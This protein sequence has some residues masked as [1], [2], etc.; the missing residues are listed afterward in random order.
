MEN[1]NNN[2]L[3]GISKLDYQREFTNIKNDLISVKRRLKAKKKVLSA[4]KE[5]IE[6]VKYLELLNNPKVIKYLDINEEISKLEY[7]EFGLDRKYEVLAQLMCKHPALL[8]TEEVTYDLGVY[9]T[10]KCLECKKIV[11][12]KEQSV[13][14]EALIYIKPRTSFY[15]INEEEVKMI[16]TEYESL[17]QTKKCSPRK[18]VRKLNNQGN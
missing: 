18:L 15:F 12:T 9:S 13:N 5:E 7:E 8:V 4:L 14:P 16:E 11:N 1:T 3:D 2:Y 17:R 6:I 10:C